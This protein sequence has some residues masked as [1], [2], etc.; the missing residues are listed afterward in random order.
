[1]LFAY[2]VNM[3]SESHPTHGMG[4]DPN[5]MQPYRTGS[6]LVLLAASP[7]PVS[8]HLHGR[9][10]DVGSVNVRGRRSDGGG[11]ARERGHCVTL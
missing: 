7:V 1:M 6:D 10:I 2:K 9:S 8:E 5:G 11:V 3:L 4:G